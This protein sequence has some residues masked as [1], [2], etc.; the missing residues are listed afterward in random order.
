VDYAEANE[1]DCD[2]N[3]LKQETDT[4]PAAG[5][6]RIKSLQRLSP[7]YRRGIAKSAKHLKVGRFF[8]L[9]ARIQLDDAALQTNGYG[10]GPIVGT[11]LRQNISNA[12]LDGRFADRK[13]SGNLFISI[14]SSNKP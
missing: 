3:A 12:A 1:H 10:V 4:W 9:L 7:A 14:A 5:E 8:L 11:K 13:L 2:Q 6:R